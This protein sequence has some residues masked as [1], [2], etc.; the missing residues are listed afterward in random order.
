[1][2]AEH[3]GHTPDAEPRQPTFADRLPAIAEQLH[4]VGDDLDAYDEI[5]DRAL[6][7]GGIETPEEMTE[8]LRQ[9]VDSSPFGPGM[10]VEERTDI[11]GVEHI[12]VGHLTDPVVGQEVDA[13]NA[14]MFRRRQ[15]GTA[16]PQSQ[17]QQPQPAPRPAEAKT[18]AE[19]KS[20]A[21]KAAK[22]PIDHHKKAEPK[23]KVEQNRPK[24]NLDRPENA[25][26]P[27]QSKGPEPVSIGK[28]VDN[29]DAYSKLK[30]EEKAAN[31]RS[32]IELAEVR[33]RIDALKQKVDQ[34]TQI[35]SSLTE[36]DIRRANFLRAEVGLR[37]IEGVEAK[38]LQDELTEFTDKW[39]DIDAR[40]NAVQQPGSNDHRS[41]FKEFQAARDELEER[42]KEL[43]KGASDDDLAAINKARALT[44]LE[45]IDSDGNTVPVNPGATTTPA[46]AGGPSTPATPAG[47]TTPGAP[48]PPATPPTPPGTTT[49]P[50]GPTPP[51]GPAAPY[52]IPPDARLA[53]ARGEAAEARAESIQALNSFQ[54]ESEIRG[55][56]NEYRAQVVDQVRAVLED[57]ERNGQ[58]DQ[59]PCAIARIIAT[60]RVERIRAER[61][62][63]LAGQDTETNKGLARKFIDKY[64]KSRK[65]RIATT[66]ALGAAT[67]ITGGGAGVIPIIAVKAGLRGI[68]GY[69]AARAMQKSHDTLGN[70]DA[71]IQEAE[72]NLADEEARYRTHLEAAQA[73][74]TAAQRFEFRREAAGFVSS[75]L[76][77]HLAAERETY[78]NDRK[79][80]NRKR[81]IAGLVG[82]AA[83]ATPFVGGA[84][85]EA[86]GDK[87]GDAGQWVSDNMPGDRGPRPEA[88]PFIGGDGPDMSR[89][90]GAPEIPAGTE[91]SVPTD[92]VN[93]LDTGSNAAHNL[94]TE[95]FTAA[96]GDSIWEAKE[97]A[98]GD[99]FTQLSQDKSVK[100]PGVTD[101][102]MNQWHGMN[103]ARQEQ[104]KLIITDRLKDVTL[105]SRGG[106]SLVEVGDSI[107][108]S[109]EAFGEA[110]KYA[111]NQMTAG[112]GA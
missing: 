84:V 14:L 81:F 11:P 55:L 66:V 83:A 28:M 34:E 25:K 9:Y 62:A 71:R 19:K 76:R 74:F 70:F 36:D 30:K 20:A 112:R 106:N 88:Q 79:T 43:A 22:K 26:T 44:G 16:Q 101:T 2:S 39:A 10:N 60:E 59:A 18:G 75:E 58:L 64:T 1:M 72:A 95:R 107:N 105:A 3:T 46:T 13:L 48:T 65:V 96:T 38:K 5:L 4:S 99:F 93:P 80:L 85:V 104:F 51:A 92:T 86:A 56:D 100:I 35:D 102:E 53:E 108:T 103:S 49:P 8:Q 68:T 12:Q 23:K 110:F 82:V 21:K 41:I 52:T 42:S 67:V 50:G 27:E 33:E 109:P 7:E 94:H 17:A 73:G 40:F 89:P 6:V 111:L 54:R 61:E 45:P 77:T 31:Q 98:V 29:I 87:I 57:L 69:T 91:S 15:L 37:P 32:P 90:E 24:V 97:H 47:P 63:Y 78:S